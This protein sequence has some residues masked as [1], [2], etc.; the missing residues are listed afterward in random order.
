[1]KFILFFLITTSLAHAKDLKMKVIPQNSPVIEA[2][3]IFKLEP[4]KGMAFN[5]VNARIKNKAKPPFRERIKDY[6]VEKVGS[7]I[8]LKLPTRDYPVDKYEILVYTKNDNR[9]LWEFWKKAPPLAFG[10]AKFEVKTQQIVVDGDPQP[11]HP[12]EAGKETLL[13]I[14]SD[15]DGVRDDVEIWMNE[16]FQNSEVRMALKESAKINQLMLQHSEDREYIRSM[17]SRIVKS[18]YCSSSIMGDDL[19]AKR[20]K[21]VK[22]MMFNTGERI[23]AFILADSQLSGM[24]TPDE[25]KNAESSQHRSFC[26]F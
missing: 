5:D 15:N 7:E 21:E 20:S 16:T 24:G 26:T 18:V 9:K 11:P 14:D 23:K 25:I 6:P 10:S 4:P 8:F 3:I 12:G 19:A 17:T 22:A 1:M 13:G 2:N